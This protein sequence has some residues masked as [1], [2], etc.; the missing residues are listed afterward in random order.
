M[1]RIRLPYRR[2]VAFGVA[3]AALIVWLSA[4][5]FE[6]GC[7]EP[8]HPTAPADSSGIKSLAQW[9]REGH[10]GGMWRTQIMGTFHEEGLSD[11]WASG[12]AFR[13]HYV[14]SSLRGWSIGVAGQF[15]YALALSDIEGADQ[16]TGQRARFELHMFD[17]EDPTNRKD[18]DRLENLTLNKTW[19]R[20]AAMFGR[21]SFESP[22]VNGQDS[23]LKAN[24]FS[25]LTGKVFL[26]KRF[27]HMVTAAVI[28]GIS[29]RGTVR[30]FGM[31]EG[32]GLLDNGLRPDGLS[33]DY[34]HRL[35][36]RGLIVVGYQH[37]G[38]EL[39]TEI[40]YHHADN[41]FAMTYGKTSVHFGNSDEWNLG[42][43]GLVQSKLGNGGSEHYEHRYYYNDDVAILAGGRLHRTTGKLGYELA[44]LFSVGSGT[45]L[46]PRE[47]GR[48]RFFTSVPRARVE[49][50][51]QFQEIAAQV[52]V[53]PTSRVKTLLTLAYVNVDDKS[54]A[55]HNKYS[56]IDHYLINGEVQVK[57]G[58][59]LENCDFRFIAA[60]HYPAD[61]N[62][63]A[64]DLYYK[65]Q[66]L[67]LSAQ[68]DMHF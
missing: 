42:L 23:R 63:T 14:T 37:F 67:H 58:K 1:A 20:G 50:L 59:I 44:G 2:S 31:D 33:A 41:L 57:G 3:T 62:Y 26:D 45:Y 36:T 16:L 54:D 19:K 27:H 35:Q 11:H 9:F 12:T 30:W 5:S 43:E 40:W 28:T 53:C 38:K 61:G 6:A 60:A 39:D 66:F 13:L 24:A 4:S 64:Q 29:P 17:I 52:D 34:E 49:G 48:E 51:G 46:F 15:G 18:F 25:G 47:W 65:A 10:F 22:F 21:F 8:D 68:M 55:L 7:T 32:L 56:L